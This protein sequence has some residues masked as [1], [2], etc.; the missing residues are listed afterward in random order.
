MLNVRKTLQ[1]NTVLNVC[2]YRWYYRSLD[3]REIT[4]TLQTT[5][6]LFINFV[7]KA[8]DCVEMVDSIFWF[9]L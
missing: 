5:I 4:Y 9:T 7:F 1:Y 2:K 6:L 8:D 3:I